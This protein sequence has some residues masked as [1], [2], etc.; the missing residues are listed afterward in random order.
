MIGVMLICFDRPAKSSWD[1]RNT[2]EVQ[3]HSFGVVEALR[4]HG[5]VYILPRETNRGSVSTNYHF[6]FREMTVIRRP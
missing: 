3:Q 4:H 1:P 2:S 5:S 6:P